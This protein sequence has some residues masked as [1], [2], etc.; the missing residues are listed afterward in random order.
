[1][2]K[3]KEKKYSFWADTWSR[4]RRNKLAMLGLF[5][6]LVLVICAVFA[7][8][9]LFLLYYASVLPQLWHSTAIVVAAHCH[10]LGSGL[11]TCWQ[12]LAHV[13]YFWLRFTR[14]AK[15]QQALY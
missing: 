4:L 1:M 3:T 15:L 7:D 6:I 10:R 8:F 11:P 2:T 9:R 13:E 12:S 5:I 14:R